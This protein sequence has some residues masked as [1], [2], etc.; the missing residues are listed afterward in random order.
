MSNSCTGADAL[1]FGALD[2]GVCLAT[3]VPGFPITGIMELLLDSSVEARWSINEKVALE[4]ALGAS[5]VGRRAVVIVKHVGMNVLA[6]PLITSVN[7]TIGAGLVIIAGDDPGTQQSQNE[8][9]SR[10]YGLIAEVQVFDP[11]DPADAYNSMCQAFRLSEE[12]SAPVIIRTT[13][14]LNIEKGVV[15]RRPPMQVEFQKFDRDIWS[16]TMKGKHQRFHASS[17]PRMQYLS[18]ESGLNVCHERGKKIGIISSGYLSTLV[19][20]VLS[21]SYEDVSHLALT[22]INP[23]PVEVINCFIKRH[24][25]TL[26]IEETETFIEHQLSCMDVLGKATGHIGHGKVE[27]ADIIQAL[28]YIDCDTIT[29]SITPETIA[30]RGFSRSI[31][32][33]CPYHMLY[34][35]LRTMEVPVAGDLGC[36]VRTASPPM[37]VVDI[38][39]SLG[40]SIATGT[41][42]DRK[43]VA[44]IGD[45]GLVHT[46]LQGLIEAVHHHRD[47]MVVVLQN[48]VAALTGGQDVPDMTE[49]VRTLV[50][51]T[52]LLDVENVTETE[53]AAL[54]NAELEKSGV[55]VLLARGTCTMY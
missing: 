40:S 10:Y 38:A 4:A 36:S 1:V 18:E 24:E 32:D 17:Y 12:V 53:L 54:L 7:H 34:K 30:G 43:G 48:K 55:S 29:L 8:Q 37:G 35:V 50:P 20:L 21:D 3:G 26:V 45:Y 15:E 33:D 52:K 47:V 46:G 49:V 16:Y 23:L 13:D 11:S 51:D 2:S 41:G 22:S 5:A 14:R 44:L 42:F 27:V 39:Y 25:R 28:E 9:D 19:E 31:C 6:D